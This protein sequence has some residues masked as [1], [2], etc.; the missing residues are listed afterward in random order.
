MKLE[1]KNLE[2]GQV[3][4]LHNKNEY[5]Y[6]Q[7]RGHIRFHKQAIYKIRIL[8]RGKCNTRL[9]VLE[10]LPLPG[11]GELKPY[12]LNQACIGEP[13]TVHNTVLDQVFITNDFL[14]TADYFKDNAVEEI[15]DKISTA[16]YQ[17]NWHLNDRA[18]KLKEIEKL[19]KQILEIDEI[20][21]PGFHNTIAEL[22][23][24]LRKQQKFTLEELAAANSI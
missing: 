17:I 21:I 11:D 5:N 22:E 24:D 15:E 8:R 13:W 18:K 20:A 6:S 12:Y 1:R 2:L 10:A 23:R 3:V 9:Q 7:E 16:K 4:Y 19:Q 14:D